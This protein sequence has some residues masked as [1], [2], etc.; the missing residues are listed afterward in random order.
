[1]NSQYF[2]AIVLVISTFVVNAQNIDYESR[3][4]RFESAECAEVGNEE[5]TW[6]GYSSDNIDVTETSSGCVTLS[7]NGGGSINGTYAT[8]NRY[9]TP[10]TTFQSRI[11]AWEDDNGSQCTYNTGWSVNDDD[12]YVEQTVNTPLN[13]PLEYQ[14]TS[15]NIITGNGTSNSR[16]FVQYRYTTTTIANAVDNNSVTY[17]TGGNRPFWGS[18]GSW[19]FSGND[20]ATSGTITNNQTSSFSFTTTCVS[21]VT[22]RW[23]VSSEANWDFLRVFVNGVQQAAISGNVGWTFQTLNLPYGASNTIEFRY[24]KD[25]SISSGEDRGFVDQIAFVSANSVDPGTISGNTTICAGQATPAIANIAAAQAYS[26]TINY[27]WQIST[28]GITWT[29]LT[30]ETNTSLSS[31]VANQTTY[32]RRRIIDGC[33]N[34]DYSNIVTIDVNTLSSPPVITSALPNICPNTDVVLVASGGVAGTGSSIRWYSGPNGTGTLLGTG[35]SITVS[36]AVNTT[37]YARREGT[38]NNTVDA[39]TTVDVRDFVYANDGET[40]TTYCTDNNGWHHFYNGNRILLS[41]QGDLSGVTNPVVTINNAGSNYQSPNLPTDCGNNVNPGEESFEMSRSWNFNANG[42]TLNGT[43]NV[44]FYYQPSERTTIENA[45][46]AWMAANPSCSY[47]YKYGNP[48]GFIWFKNTGSNYTA[49]DYDGTQLS[50]TVSSIAGINYT[51]LT[52]IT[53]FSGGSGSV[54]LVPITGLPVSLSSYEADCLDNG[55]VAVRWTS[56]SEVNASHYTVERSTDGYQWKQIREV[57]AAGNS[58]SELNYEILDF[59][60]R[61]NESTYYRLAQFDFDGTKEILGTTTLKCNSS[62]EGFELYPNPATDAVTIKI[63]GYSAEQRIDLILFDAQGQRI[64]TINKVNAT[65]NVVSMD[66]SKLAAGYYLIQL[67]DEEGKIETKRLIKK[68]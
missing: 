10:V 24:T 35:N 40:S 4:T 17:S 49:P 16:T 42:G 48:N 65:G 8:R 12:C 1:M 22:F 44:R 11:R 34:V 37:Y 20:C 62:Q 61:G 51:E 60:I 13:N 26:G 39:S 9:N 27:Q 33:G 43:Y 54:I 32:L 36:P 63:H 23:R 7:S 18:L 29:N 25:G 15:T 56:I 66:I 31:I 41:V 50:G 5:Y 55:A 28:N 14:W 57:E 59:D 67:I 2:S 6:Y 58:N 47:T 64:R 30:G 19:A 45:A 21:Q 46:V 68:D 38:C 53:S 3:I 52:G